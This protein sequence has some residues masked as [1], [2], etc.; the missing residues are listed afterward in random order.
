MIKITHTGTQDI[1]TERLLLR[2]FVMSDANEIFREW[3]SY[4][5]VTKY[6]T[7]ESHKS[8]SETKTYLMD[9]IGSYEQPDRYCWGIEL[10]ELGILIGSLSMEIISENARVANAGYCLGERFWNC[11]YVTEAMRAAADYMFYDV[12]INRIEAYHSVGNPASGR[13]MQKIGMIKEGFSRQKYITGRGEYQDADLYGFLKEDFEKIYRPAIKDFLDL[14]K[15][16][17]SAYNLFL[18]CCEYYEGYEKDNPFPAYLFKITGSNSEIV[19]GEI[20][21]RLGFNDDMYY[22]GHIGFTVYEGYRNMGVATVACNIVLELVKA[23]GFKK[24]II[25]NNHINKASKRVCEK[26]GAKLIRTA[27]L[28]EWHDLYKEGQRFVCIYEV[29]L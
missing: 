24:V 13:V 16:N 20:T 21:L 1:E 9:A 22:G 10:K 11:G 25:T 7:W 29:E 2:R 8:I 12:N 15:I 17:L 19:F 14:N 5:E 3:A 18:K 4:P 23:H 28:P 26:I 6:L 27:R